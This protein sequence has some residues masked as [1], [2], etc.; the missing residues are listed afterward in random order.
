[1]KK[2]IALVVSVVMLAMVLTSCYPAILNTTMSINL[3]G[4]GTRTFVVELLK[5]GTVNPDDGTK[6]VTGMFTDPGYFP[7]GIQPAIDYLNTIRPAA[8]S[9]LTATEETDRYVVTFTMEFDSIDD[10]NTKMHTLTADL[11]WSAEE[12]VDATLTAVLGETQTAYTYTEDIL[13]VNI[14]SLWMS[15]GLWNSPQDETKIFDVAYAQGQFN[16]QKHY[17]DAD[18]V[19]YAMFFTNSTTIDLNGVEETF[20]QTAEEVTVTA[21]FDNPVESV[22]ESEAESVVESEAESEEENPQT[23][24]SSPIAVIALFSV[25]AV[26]AAIV[27]VQKKVS[28]K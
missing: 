14:G 28:A 24:D 25:L 12:V 13:L 3:D 9:A 18:A 1:M 20:G 7:Q 17:N 4:S 27:L 5:D 26:M 15:N 8:L 10:F 22:A 16:W 11:D 19:Q 2:L 6:S 21:S 23:S